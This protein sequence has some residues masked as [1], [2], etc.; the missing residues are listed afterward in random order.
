MKTVLITGGSRG[1]GR[2]LS[3]AFGRAGYAVGVNFLKDHAA[4]E[5]VVQEIW[6][7][8]NKEA[9]SF[10]CDVRDSIKVRQMVDAMVVRWKRLDVLV[11][12]A[13]VTR[14]RTILKMTNG[15]W[16]EVL[17]VNLTGAFWCLREA[18]RV[19]SQQKAGSILNVS[20]IMGMRGGFGN[21]N[22]AAAKAGLIGLTKGAARELGRFHITV[23]AVLP[24]F[25]ETDMANELTDEHRKKI[26]QE[27]ALGK[28]TDIKDLSKLVLELAEN[29]SISGQVFNVDSRVI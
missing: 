17:D 14:D 20:S 8:G 24:G 25:H 16:N 22:Y 28:T 10:Q 7:S 1:I 9:E 26:I 15:E 23:N 29:R 2:E 4:A 3:L 18:A 11:N 19:M 13:G 5:K 21:A 27:Q 12:N 6:E